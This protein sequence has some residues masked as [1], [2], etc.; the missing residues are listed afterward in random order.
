MSVLLLGR[1]YRERFHLWVQ[2]VVADVSVQHVTDVILF[3][4]LVELPPSMFNH[5]SDDCNEVDRAGCE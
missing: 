5:A 3:V 4:V 2:I 1:F